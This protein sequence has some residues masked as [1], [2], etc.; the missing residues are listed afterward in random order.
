MCAWAV[1]TGLS[2]HLLFLRIRLDI[3]PIMVFGVVDVL[4]KRL[5]K[6]KAL[7]LFHLC[8][9]I[10]ILVI[11]VFFCSFILNR[12]FSIRIACYIRLLRSLLHNCFG[13]FCHS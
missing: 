10:A 13:Y 8:E 12:I 4:E 3:T 7:I 9:H 11:L 2:L 1:R 6:K 5:P